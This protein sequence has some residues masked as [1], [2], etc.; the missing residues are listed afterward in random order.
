MPPDY[1]LSLSNV[2]NTG[3]CALIN[4]GKNHRAMTKISERSRDVMKP[5]NSLPVNTLF[6]WTVNF[7]L[8]FVFLLLLLHVLNQFS[9]QTCKHQFHF[10][11]YLVLLKCSV[12]SVRLVLSAPGCLSKSYTMFIIHVFFFSFC[13]IFIY[14]GVKK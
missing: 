6:S 13:I 4:Q 12:S 11:I 1:T 5:K 14:I 10:I 2:T 9:P 3:S 8:F 7:Q